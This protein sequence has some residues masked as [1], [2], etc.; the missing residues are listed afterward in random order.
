MA[1]SLARV[2]LHLIFG[3]KN[4]HAFLK[5]QTERQKLYFYLGGI[6]RDLECPSLIINGMPDHTH[7]LFE[8]ARTASISDVVE[9]LKGSSSKWVKTSMPG[10]RDF[11]WQRGYAV[12]SVSITSVDSVRA[13]IANQEEHH[14]TRSYQDEMQEFFRAHAFTEA[15]TS[16]WE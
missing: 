7:V 16:F 11:A 2:T 1:Q 12:F 14:R 9:G 6:L 10:C 5:D 13:Y 8:L 15:E 4:R 3:T